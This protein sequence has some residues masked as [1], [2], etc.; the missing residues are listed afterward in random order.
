MRK[1]EANFRLIWEKESKFVVRK[2]PVLEAT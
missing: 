2:M 1:R